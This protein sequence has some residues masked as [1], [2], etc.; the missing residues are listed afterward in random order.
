MQRKT[1]L[2]PLQHGKHVIP[3]PEQCVVEHNRKQDNGKP[4]AEPVGADLQPAIRADLLDPVKLEGGFSNLRPRHEPRRRRPPRERRCA[5]VSPAL[6][7]HLCQPLACSLQLH[8][9]NLGNFDGLDSHLP[10]WTSF[11]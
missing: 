5:S 3:L 8:R 9:M 6:A 11:C 1:A 2:L 10:Y 4:S 7:A